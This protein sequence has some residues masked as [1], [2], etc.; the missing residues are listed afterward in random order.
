MGETPVFNEK[1]Y[2]GRW[3]GRSYANNVRG[4]HYTETTN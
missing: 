2:S 3:F 1:V 4:I